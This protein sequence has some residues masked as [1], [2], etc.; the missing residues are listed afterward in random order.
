MS[1][2]VVVGVSGTV[3]GRTEGVEGLAL[4]AEPDMGVDGGRDADVGVS[5]EFFDDDEFDAF[6]QEEG[7]CGVAEV[8]EADRAELGVG[9][10]AWKVRMRLVCS[11]GRPMV[12]VKTY[13]VSVH[14]SAA[15]CFS[16]CCRP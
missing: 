6:L 8:V 1:V 11:I 10:R 16:C 3:E 15:D 12:V 2:A 7:G 14:W 13:P 4:E 9:R 5:E